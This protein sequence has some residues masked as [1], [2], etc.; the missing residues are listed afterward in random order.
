M[1]CGIE[2]PEKSTELAFLIE[3]LLKT[4]FM[5]LEIKKKNCTVFV[6]YFHFFIFKKI[7]FY[8]EAKMI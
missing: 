1:S 8:D 3:K 7:W 5:V 2:S 6:N 4:F